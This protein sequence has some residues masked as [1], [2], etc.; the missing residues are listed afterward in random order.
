[1]SRSF[2]HQVDAFVSDYII[3][4]AIVL[5]DLSQIITVIA[6]NILAILLVTLKSHAFIEQN[7]ILILEIRSVV[8]LFLQEVLFLIIG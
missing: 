2:I 4:S 5:V 3:L 8:T 7:F 6:L 1:M